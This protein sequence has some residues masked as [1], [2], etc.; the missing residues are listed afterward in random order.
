MGRL[1]LPPGH[2]SESREDL[3]SDQSSLHDGRVS[4]LVEDDGKGFDV[5]QVISKNPS[6]QGLGLA[7]M[8]ER[9][10]EG[11]SPI[12]LLGW[13]LPKPFSQVF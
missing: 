1:F 2:E 8:E 3:H 11:L 4:F 13:S 9:A 5:L 10:S 7:T 6:E 12:T